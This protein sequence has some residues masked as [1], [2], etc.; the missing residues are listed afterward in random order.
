MSTKTEKSMFCE[1]L[2]NCDYQ[3]LYCDRHLKNINIKI[4]KTKCAILCTVYTH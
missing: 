4:L 3:L 1:F 2:Q